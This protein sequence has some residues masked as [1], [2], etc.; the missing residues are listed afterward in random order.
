MAGMVGSEYVGG[1]K[2][3][4]RNGQESLVYLS[5]S[6]CVGEWKDN[7]KQGQGTQT[8]WMATFNGNMLENL[9]TVEGMR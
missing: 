5:G 8:F 6:K 7:K 1:Y 2:D 3:D 4:K 9:E